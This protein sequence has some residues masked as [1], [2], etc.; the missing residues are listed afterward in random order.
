M[1]YY[2]EKL[3]RLLLLVF[4]FYGFMQTARR[5]LDV[6]LSLAFIFASIGSLM[7][8]AGILNLLPET[9]AF[10]CLL[11]CALGVC[12]IRRRDSVL[13]LVSPGTLFFAV[14]SVVMAAL[15]LRTKFTS[16]D[17]F[18]HWAIVVKRMLATDRFPNF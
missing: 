1:L 9:A 11:G 16:Y 12:S 18:S 8:A 3:V 4:S 14:G 15:L 6:N 7:F 10:I 2:A 13:A 5:R 17:N